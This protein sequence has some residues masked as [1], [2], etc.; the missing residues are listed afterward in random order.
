MIEFITGPSG[1][2]KTSLMYERIKE[3]TLPKCIIVPE[4]FSHD[5]DKKLYY[6]LGAKK[7][8]EVFSLS[9]TGL[10]RQLFQL[11]GDPSRGGEYADDMAKMILVYQAITNVDK[12]LESS[13]LFDDRLKHKTSDIAMIYMEYQRLMEEY[14]FKDEL[15][16][17]TEAAK[18]A[19]LQ[20]YFK[21]MSVYIDEF[22][23]FTAD[24]VAMLKVMILTAENVSI[25][26]RTDDIT[27]GK[28][29]LFEAVNKTY[30]DIV[31]ICNDL[32]KEYKIIGQKKIKIQVDN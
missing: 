27:A 9:F 25:T 30:H 6:F 2:G 3:D 18:I 7:F 24:Q 19:N 28:Y 26:L 21:G 16:N 4:Q 22:E 20:Q 17:I 14:G 23:S 15:D 11:F 31:R 12:L 5:F 1:S 29:T 10:S 13:D 8:N 32:H